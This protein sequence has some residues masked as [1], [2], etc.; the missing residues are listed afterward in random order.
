MSPAERPQINGREV[1]VTGIDCPL[2]ASE[3]RR[4]IGGNTPKLR[5]IAG[6]TRT[7]CVGLHGYIGTTDDEQETTR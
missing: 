7:F 6:E 5:R 2:C 4:N 1:E 3:G